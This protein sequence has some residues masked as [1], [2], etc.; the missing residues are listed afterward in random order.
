MGRVEVAHVCSGSGGWSL[1]ERC[2]VARAR[3]VVFPARRRADVH[4]GIMEPRRLRPVSLDEGHAPI[5]GLS[6]LALSSPY[7]LDDDRHRLDAL[8]A[9]VAF[10]RAPTSSERLSRLSSTGMLFPQ[11]LPI[12]PKS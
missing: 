8:T 11:T 6:R 2:A 5:S 3:L 7:M 4:P 9:A 1:M 10:A 12:E